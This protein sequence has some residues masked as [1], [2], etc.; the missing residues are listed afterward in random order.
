MYNASEQF[1]ELNKANV[2]QAT[3]IAALALATPRSS[4]R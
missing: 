3:K 2:A 1:A 4:S